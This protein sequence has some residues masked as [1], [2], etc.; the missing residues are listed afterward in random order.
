IL[1]M[2]AAQRAELRRSVLDVNAYAASGQAAA[3]LYQLREY[4]DTVER[5]ASDPAVRALTRGPLKRPFPGTNDGADQDPC[6]SQVSLEVPTA[7]EPYSSRFATLTVLDEQGCARARISEEAAPAEYARHSYSWRDYFASAARDAER[8]GRITYVRPAYR[9]SVSQQIK[10]AVSRPLFEGERWIGVVYGSMVAA[11]TLDLP[12]MKR[13]DTSERMTV[14]IGPFEGE[15][16]GPQDPYTGQEFTLL[17]HPRLERGRKVSLTPS[18][19]REL[20]QA[21]GR[22]GKDQRQFELSTSLPYQ[23]A[24]HVDPLLGGRWLAAFAPVGAT[25]YVVLVQ[26]RDDLAVRPSNGLWRTGFVLAF[27][28]AALLGVWGAFF[29]WRWRREHPR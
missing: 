17:A 2:A 22:P 19:A 9:S 7:L 12:R 18:T 29:V 16:S 10:F 11:S 1:L 8:P 28:S 14:L 27:G 13:S 21:L 24:D 5:A 20:V 4:A 15:R 3:V 26:T 23:R 25:G 6:R